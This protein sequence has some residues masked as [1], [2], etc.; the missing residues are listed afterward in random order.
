M[1][2][3]SLKVADE[4]TNKKFFENMSKRAMETMQ[5]EMDYM[6][7]VRLKDVEKAQHEIVAIVRELD[8]EGVISI[9]GGEEEQFV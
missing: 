8:E 2:T 5:E 7:P 1:L 4:D 9:G 6:G 3:F